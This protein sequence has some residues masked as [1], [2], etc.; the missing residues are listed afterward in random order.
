MMRLLLLSL[1]LVLLALAVPSD[2]HRLA[3]SLLQG[4]ELDADRFRFTWQEPAVTP[5]GMPRPR[6][7]LPEHCTA[8]GERRLEPT[9]TP[10][11][12]ALNQVWDVDC[13]PGGLFGTEIHVSDLEGGGVALLRLNFN[14]G[15][16]LTRLLNESAPTYTVPR[17]Q[18]FWHTSLEYIRLGF[19]HILGGVDHLLFIFALLLL[20]GT[21]K[22]LVVTIT[23]FTI[24]HSITLS[25]AAL[26]LI[27]FGSGTV[28]F[29]VAL[30]IFWVV[31]ELVREPEKRGFVGRR[32]AAGAALFGL[33]HGLGFAATLQEVG[34]P[35]REIPA[36]LLSFN[37]GVELGQLVFVAGVA[38]M[39]WVAPAELGRRVF[40]FAVY[41]LGTLSAFWCIERGLTML[42]FTLS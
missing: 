18:G 21:L 25:L 23:M 22:A 12:P 29:L 35:V 1:G 19:T 16:S 10:T 4:D 9:R 14:N 33:L 15:V 32:P 30:S 37:I 26:G 41:L 2:A 11:G 38:V 28:E 3:P 24:S 7:V 39:R 31:L 20:I 27:A 13:A 6:P 42:G 36:A 40:P 8:L 34:L 17:S 5:T